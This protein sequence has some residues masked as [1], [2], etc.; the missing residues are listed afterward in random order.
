[1]HYA[2]PTPTPDQG[3]GKQLGLCFAPLGALGLISAD[4][5]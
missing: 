1:M 4:L 3:L 2:P 5:Q